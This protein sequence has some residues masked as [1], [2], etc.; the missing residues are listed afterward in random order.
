MQFGKN[1]R[2][3]KKTQRYQTFNKRS[4]KELFSVRTK[5][6][7]KKTKKAKQNSENVL[8]IEMNKKTYS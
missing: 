4:K 6:S 1:H 7:K 5:L 2:K 8:T 3:C